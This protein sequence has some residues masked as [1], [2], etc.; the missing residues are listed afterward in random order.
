MELIQVTS[1][2]AKNQIHKLI[3]NDLG[4]V[5]QVDSNSIRMVLRDEDHRVYSLT[6]SFNE[7]F[8]VV[9]CLK[10]QFLINRLGI[11]DAA[12][13]SKLLKKLLFN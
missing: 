7:L 11:D 1:K 3:A 8:R 4:I 9:M 13:L 10:A 5:E 6:L 12:K 2:H